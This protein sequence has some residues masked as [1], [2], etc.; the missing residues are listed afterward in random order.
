LAGVRFAA[1]CFN[2]QFL[3]NYQFARHSN[4]DVSHRGGNPGFVELVDDKTFRIPDY[5]GNSMFNTFGNLMLNDKAGVVFWDFEDG[6]LLQMTGTA[7]IHWDTPDREYSE[8]GRYWVFK[9][10]K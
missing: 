4:L 7:L 10:E 8:T 3:R 1:G 5:Q 9:I 2:F 6:K